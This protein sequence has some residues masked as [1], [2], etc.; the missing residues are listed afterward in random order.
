MSRDLEARE[1]LKL[2]SPIYVHLFLK[3]YSREAEDIRRD[4]AQGRV[5]AVAVVNDPRLVTTFE[6]D[7]ILVKENRVYVSPSHS[8]EGVER[9]RRVIEKSGKKYIV[10]EGGDELDFY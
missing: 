5:H 3:N 6:I 8:V 9:V 4:I 7:D 2:E 1:A 10:L